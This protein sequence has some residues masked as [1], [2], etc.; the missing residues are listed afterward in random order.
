MSWPTACI[1]L[2]LVLP[3]IAGAQAESEHES[4]RGPARTQLELFS[5]ELETLHA[6]F[7]QKV[8]STD[9]AVEDGSAGQVWLRRPQLFR[10]EYGGD[11][12]EV[13]VAD[14]DNIW[15]YDEMLEQVTVKDQSQA[16]V[17]SPLTLLTDLSQLDRQ[18]EVR[19]VGE[20]EGMQ[21][22]ELRSRNMETEFERILLGLQNDTLKLMVMEDAFGLRTEIVFTEVSR[23]PELDPL[24]FTFVPPDTADVIG[25]PRSAPSGQ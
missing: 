24:L 6:R 25:D 3:G 23:N 11:F 20:M 13:V 2:F 21:L 18:F 4:G 16:A 7:E 19:E 10:W 12:P 17:D 1:I 9:G 15:I 8:V 14:G 22:L 5:N